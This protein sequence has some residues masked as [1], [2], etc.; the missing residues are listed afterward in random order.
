LL[1]TLA[2]TGYTIATTETYKTFFFPAKPR[3]K[4]AGMPIRFPEMLRRRQRFVPLY[5]AIWAG[6]LAAIAGATHG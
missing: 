2:A 3:G 6:V 5:V 1:V 4:F